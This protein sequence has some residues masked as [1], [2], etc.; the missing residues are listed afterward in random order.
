VH[1]LCVIDRR[2]EDK[3]A[4]RVSTLP[5]QQW[6]TAVGECSVR[7]SRFQLDGVKGKAIVGSTDYNEIVHPPQSS[8]TDIAEL[9]ESYSPYCYSVFFTR[10]GIYQ[11][12]L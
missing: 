5:I 12:H 4:A 3:K 11:V 10:I 7:R 2:C 1:V 8:Q 9:A 6:G